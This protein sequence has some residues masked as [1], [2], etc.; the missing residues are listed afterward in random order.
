MIQ[1]LG[2][3]ADGSI[4]FGKGLETGPWVRVEGVEHL[5]TTTKE[6]HEC[7]V[8]G[9]VRK[10]ELKKKLHPFYLTPF[11]LFQRENGDVTIS[12]KQNVTLCNS[13]IRYLND[14]DINH[15]IHWTLLDPVP[16]T[17]IISENLA[18]TDREAKT[19]H[20]RDR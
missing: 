7:P 11:S 10:L 6:T 9:T 3:I 4:K 18:K 8:N 17:K 16:F 19:H 15:N 14:L 20:K 2:Q 12:N 1:L 5:L 13:Y